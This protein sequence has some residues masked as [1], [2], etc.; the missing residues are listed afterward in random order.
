ML[1]FAMALSS[2]LDKTT[3]RSESPSTSS[4][5]CH[6][7]N[8]LQSK[9]S[10]AC[11]CEP[12]LNYSASRTRI[13]YL[14]VYSVFAV[15]V[16]QKCLAQWMSNSNWSIHTSFTLP[17]LLQFT[18]AS[19]DYSPLPAAVWPPPYPRCSIDFLF[20]LFPIRWCSPLLITR[21]LVRL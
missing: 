16:T 11:N 6:F 12:I 9:P 2:V 8:R 14:T 19:N 7:P 3:I 13:G 18:H 4:S 10:S 20:N 21:R 5:C 1:R 17:S 15:G